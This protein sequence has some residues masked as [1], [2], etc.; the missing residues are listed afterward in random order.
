M[1]LTSSEGYNVTE[2]F[3]GKEL[4]KLLPSQN[5]TAYV[6]PTGVFMVKATILNGKEGEGK[7]G[8]ENR[9]EEKGKGENMVFEGKGKEEDGK[10]EKEFG[11]ER[12]G[13]DWNF[14]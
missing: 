12:N 9:V 14:L 5:L 3:D 4:G 13:M 8:G 1:G 11:E 7:K 10:G 6:N 2:L